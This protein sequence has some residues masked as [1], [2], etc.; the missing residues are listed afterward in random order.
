LY[1]ESHVPAAIIGAFV[2]ANVMNN[3]GSKRLDQTKNRRWEWN[4]H[5]HQSYHHRHLDERTDYGGEC[6]AAVTPEQQRQVGSDR[7]QG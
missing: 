7:Y 1:I 6:G 5:I 3:G 4:A 2:I